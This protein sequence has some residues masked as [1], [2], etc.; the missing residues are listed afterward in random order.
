VKVHYELK[1]LAALKEVFEGMEA[2]QLVGR[3]VLKCE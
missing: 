3:V 1:P 2:G